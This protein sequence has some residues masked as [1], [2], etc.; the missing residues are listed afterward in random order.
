[1][2]DFTFYREFY[3]YCMSDNPQTKL[4]YVSMKEYKSTMYQ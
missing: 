1:M 3:A 4:V 2:Q